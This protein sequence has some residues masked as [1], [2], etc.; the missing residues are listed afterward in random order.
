MINEQQLE[1]ITKMIETVIAEDPTY[2]LVEVKIKPTNNVKVF[3]DGDSGIS[4]QKVAS[5]NRALYKLLEESN[6]FP[7]GD[8]SLEVSSPGLEEP[9][10]LQRQFQKNI[11]RDVEVLT[12]DGQ[13]I[14]GKMVKAD[15]EAL[16]IEEEKGKQKKKEIIQHLVPLNTIK[17]TK[18]QIKF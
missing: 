16:T 8:F 10:K 7:D 11:G 1:A 5:Y 13:K 6:M 3:L 17:S 18:I 4:I 15:E 2:F 12:K 14:E 9:L